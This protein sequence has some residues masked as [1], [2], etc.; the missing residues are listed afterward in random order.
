MVA[1]WLANLVDAS[2]RALEFEKAE[3]DSGPGTVSK[4]GFG[5][6]IAWREAGE[7]G[8]VFAERF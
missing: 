2:L 3:Y 6:T 8:V 7:F 1:V 5:F 4:S